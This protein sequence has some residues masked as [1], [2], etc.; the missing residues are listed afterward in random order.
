[1]SR[2]QE[3]LEYVKDLRGYMDKIFGIFVVIQIII[4]QVEIVWCYYFEI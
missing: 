4:I 1:M 3:L 2:Y